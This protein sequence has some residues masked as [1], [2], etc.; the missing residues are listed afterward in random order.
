MAPHTPFE[1]RLRVASRIALYGSLMLAIALGGVALFSTRRAVR[2]AVDL[3]WYDEDWGSIPE[4]Q[5][6]QGFLRV[7]TSHET[8]SELEGA[9][10]LAQ[11]LSSV[12]IEPVIEPLGNDR[13]NLWAVI[14]GKRREA[15]VLHNHLDVEPVLEES[16]WK[17]PPFAG[18]ID[19]PWMF[20]RGA[21]DMKSVAIAQLETM[22]SVKRHLDATGDRPEYSLLFLATSSEESGSELGTQWIL[23]QHPELVER[24]WAVLGE[25][26]V[27]EIMDRGLIKYW[28]TSFAQKH[29]VKVTAC[30][31]SR[32]RLEAFLEDV[33]E[34]TASN[35]ELR[36]TPEVST[37]L[38]SYAQTRDEPYIR[39][40]LQ[41]PERLANDRRAFEF[42]PP[43]LRSLFRDESHPFPLVADEN[44][45]GYSL[46]VF[47]HLLPGSSTE[48]S[49]RRLLPDWVTHGLSLSIEEPAAARH[50]SP[51][52]HPAFAA[53]VESIDE[54]HGP[55]EQGPYFL[56]YYAND[57]RFWRSRGIPYYGFSPFAIFASDTLS[58]GHP[59]ERIS[60]PEF[61]EG[62]FLYRRTV[63]R[64]LGLPVDAEPARATN[65]PRGE[66]D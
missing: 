11:L 25:G 39:W 28:G 10:Y 62:V 1:R 44:S 41:H 55:V 46:K 16:A 47:V 17:H 27:V 18:V 12:G 23:W 48:D 21:F 64:L 8:G 9:R 4:V 2:A 26:G 58:V 52:D 66:R 36:I 5:R 65:G 6:L 20:G 35:F 33:R 42:L 40:L 38:E 24:F 22:L 34:V 49:L 37:F 19:P 29:F 32:E 53:V 31:S 15:L 7:D 60:L 13:A 57:G 50:G 59:N 3:S 63:S 45:G 30:S 51:T 14:E 54:L 43:Y 61:L 56:S